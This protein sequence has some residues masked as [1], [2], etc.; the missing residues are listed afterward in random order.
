MNLSIKRTYGKTL[1]IVLAV[2]MLLTGPVGVLEAH[3]EDGTPP[4]VESID[5]G[6]QGGSSTATPSD[7]PLGTSSVQ[8]SGTPIQQHRAGGPILMAATATASATAGYAYISVDLSGTTFTDDAA[9]KDN[10]SLGGDSGLPIT[11]ISKTDTN[12]FLQ[13]DDYVEEGD[14]ITVSAEA[15]ALTDESTLT[16]VSVM[17]HI[18][19]AAV[20]TATATV[21][22][23]TIAVNLTQGSFAD[24]S[25]KGNWTLSGT[26]A[27]GNSIDAVAYQNG[28]NVTIT[29]TNPIGA[30]DNYTLQAKQNAFGNIMTKPFAAPLDVTINSGGATAPAF[31]EGYPKAGSMQMAG[32]RQVSVVINAQEAAYYDFVLLPDK[33]GRTQRRA[34]AGRQRR[35]RPARFE[36]I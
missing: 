29:L 15:A 28:S 32:S 22:G 24:S 10:W 5:S 26:S 23:K 34:G 21:G 2:S 31:A 35:G 18:P 13:L 1:A 4:A 33:A 17:I 16:D 19:I 7:V 9:N 11:S 36:S 27:G 3:A 14:T 12:A 8:D 25:N 6:T 20:G 30:S